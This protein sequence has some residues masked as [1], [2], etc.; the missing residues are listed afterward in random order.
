MFAKALILSLALAAS[1][2]V[3][4]SAEIQGQPAE[5]CFTARADATGAIH[6]TMQL[7]AG[8]YCQVLVTRPFLAIDAPQSPRRGRLLLT[9]TGFAYAADPKADGED[10]F[11]L[12]GLVA[13]PP[14]GA[15]LAFMMLVTVQFAAAPGENDRRETARGPHAAAPGA[16]KPSGIA[17]PE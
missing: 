1:A 5:P 15:P 13:P 7:A 3:A 6:A 16:A 17:L 2:P 11:T 8:E 14:G 4:V 10:S 12:T 9:A